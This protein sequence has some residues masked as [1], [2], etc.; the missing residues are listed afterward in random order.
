MIYE[1]ENSA[2]K[3]QILYELRGDRLLNM[4]TLEFERLANEIDKDVVI[5]VSKQITMIKVLLKL[6]SWKSEIRKLS[7][8]GGIL[9]NDQKVDQLEQVQLLNDKY[10]L[11]QIGKRNVRLLIFI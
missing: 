3:N 4:S 7:L 1:D 11:L 10:I 2:E 6:R 9:I 8:Q 5:R